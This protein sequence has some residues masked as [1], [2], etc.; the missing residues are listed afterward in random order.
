MSL[1]GFVAA[2]VLLA[3][4]LAAAACSEPTRWANP[5]VPEDG[6]ALDAQ[7]CRKRA[8]TRVERAYAHEEATAERSGVSGVGSLRQTMARHDAMSWRDDL[9]ADCMRAKGYRQVPLEGAGSAK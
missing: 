2:P 3:A 1:K 4:V 6:W 8:A 9:F 5:G 7:E